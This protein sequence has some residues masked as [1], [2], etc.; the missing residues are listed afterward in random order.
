MIYSF[1]KMDDPN[2]R[3]ILHW[4]YDEPYAIYN[5]QLKD[6]QEDLKVFLDPQNAYHSVHDE[7][8]AMIAYRCFG[9]IARVPGGDY[10]ADALDTGGGLRPDLTGRGLG[11]EV[12]SAGL[13]FARRVFQPRAFRV[14]IAEFNVRAQKVFRKAQFEFVQRFNGGDSGAAFVILMKEN[15]G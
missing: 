6:M 8:G 4:R 9:S 12:L 15:A 2:A 11:L 5:A 10:T 3:S 14:T 1:A 7:T 13:D